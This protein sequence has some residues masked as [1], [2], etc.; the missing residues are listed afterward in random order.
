MVRPVSATGRATTDAAGDAFATPGASGRFAADAE[1]PAAASGCN[2][3]SKGYRRR[4]PPGAG[5]RGHR[6]RAPCSA[7]LTTSP[8]S[9]GCTEQTLSSFVPIRVPVPCRDASRR[10][11]VWRRSAAREDSWA[12][13]TFN[14]D[15]GWAGWKPIESSV[16]TVRAGRLLQ[17]RDNDVNVDGYR[18]TGDARTPAAIRT[19]PASGADLKA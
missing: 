1:A 12:R 11:H 17:A 9:W 19:L 5:L 3:R 6:R 8:P 13:M 4:M 10:P 18:P 14:D 16:H 15:G 2:A 7:R